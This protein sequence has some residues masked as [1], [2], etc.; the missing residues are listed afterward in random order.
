MWSQSS[1][2]HLSLDSCQPEGLDQ[3]FLRLPHLCWPPGVLATPQRSPRPPVPMPSSLPWSQAQVYF[4]VWRPGGQG[5]PQVR[6]GPE[7]GAYLAARWP[8]GNT[9]HFPLLRKVSWELKS[10]GARVA[11]GAVLWRITS[12]LCG[13]SPSAPNPL[14]ITHRHAHVQSLCHT[15]IGRDLHILRLS[16]AKG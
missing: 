13:P 14:V 6:E 5:L 10:A 12:G 3:P 4:R 2:L 16:K 11:P 1:V 15:F 9:W 7:A 8:G